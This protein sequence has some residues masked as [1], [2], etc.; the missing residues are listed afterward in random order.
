MSHEVPAFR[1]LSLDEVRSVALRQFGNVTVEDLA[2][3]VDARTR[4]VALASVHFQSGWRLDVERV[5]RFL[6]E[7]GVLFCLDGIQSFGAL[8]TQAIAVAGWLQSVGVKA[9]DREC[10]RI[11]C[12]FEY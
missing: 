9:G 6:K 2:P 4:L 11:A 12:R 3:H 8:R 1:P 10:N 7:R 5:G